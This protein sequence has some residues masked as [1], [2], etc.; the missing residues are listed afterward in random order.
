M[1]DKEPV[2]AGLEY[3]GGLRLRIAGNSH[4]TVC[5]Y[6]DDSAGHG[7]PEYQTDG[8]AGC[9]LRAAEDMWIPARSIRTVNTGLTIEL[10]HGWEAQ[11]RARSGLAVRHHVG[12]F[13][14]GT[15]D[16]DYRGEI[17]VCLHNASA[18]DFKVNRGDRI[19]QLVFAPVYRA[20]FFPRAA[21]DMSRTDRG[22]GGFGSTGGVSGGVR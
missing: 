14:Q 17:A 4:R 8:A 19:A 20:D 16:S 13:L 22:D 10:P 21:A 9:D 12:A 3:R 1:M 15:I 6:A 11:V 2:I 5:V 7:F 18:L